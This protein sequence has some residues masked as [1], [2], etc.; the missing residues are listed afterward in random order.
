VDRDLP[1]RQRRAGD[2]DRGYESISL[3]LILAPGELR[4]FGAIRLAKARG[5]WTGRVVDAAGRGVSGVIHWRVLD[6]RPGVPASAVD[7][8]EAAGGEFVQSR[9][10]PRRYLALAETPAHAIGWRVV[11]ARDAPAPIEVQVR[12]A[13]AVTFAGTL[14][15]LTSMRV[16]VHDFSGVPIW[17][18]R[19][20]GNEAR[21]CWLPAGTYRAELQLPDGSTRSR[22]F[23][24]SGG[25][26]RITVP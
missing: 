12:P 23:V 14:P 8:T 3:P 5:E 25:T 9:L 2:P 7:R 18:E 1:R 17:S 13:S 6:E 16:T 20:V 22:P 19:I 4:D 15:E 21:S 11:D 26:H 24:V 10:G